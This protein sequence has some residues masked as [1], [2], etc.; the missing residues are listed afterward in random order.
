M[1]FAALAAAV[2]PLA[3]LAQN[4]PA[5]VNSRDWLVELLKV[6][7]VPSLV[8][9]FVV[10]AQ[11]TTGGMLGGGGA[12]RMERAVRNG[13]F[14]RLSL[15]TTRPNDPPQSKS[16]DARDRMRRAFDA[17]ADPNSPRLECNAEKTYL[18]DEKGRRFPYFPYVVA[19][20]TQFGAGSLELVFA[21]PWDAVGLKLR[22]SDGFDWLPLPAPD[23]SAP[24]STSKPVA[25]RGTIAAVR[26]GD[27][28]EVRTATKNLVLAD[29]AS[30]R[31]FG[32]ILDPQIK[33]TL[34]N[35]DYT[36]KALK[37]DG[38]K[39]GDSVELATVEGDPEVFGIQAIPKAVPPAKAKTPARRVPPAKTGGAPAAKKGT[40]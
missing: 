3:L 39:V 13:R 34:S 6:D 27:A 17:M 33:V 28:V 8:N 19:G 31:K 21:V 22:L 5:T 16:G 30:F 24:A 9:Q 20:V 37:Y 35:A 18:E 12:I 26:P 7:T 14:L 1:R 36:M 15:K 32:G 23:A 40:P 29:L 25:I 38:L 11:M 4:P 10:G 2:L